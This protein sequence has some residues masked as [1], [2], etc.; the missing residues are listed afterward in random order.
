LLVGLALAADEQATLEISAQ[1][2]AM[3]MAGMGMPDV[4]ELMAG[5][6]PSLLASIPGMADLP[7]PG[8]AMRMLMVQ[9]TSPGI[10]P[11]G[12]TASLAVPPALKL[13][14]RLDLEIARPVQTPLAQGADTG[15]LQLTARFYW[16]SSP[17][18]KPGQPEVLT[19]DA[20]TAE[21]RRAIAQMRADT[22]RQ[23]KPGLPMI[24]EGWTWASW[25]TAEQ[26]GLLAKDAALPGGYALTTNYTGN[27]SLDAPQ[28][29]TFLGPI[30][31]TSPALKE[32]PPL[33]APIVLRWKPV[34]GVLGYSAMIVAMQ[35]QNTLVMWASSEVSLMETELRV[36]F[37]PTEKVA[38]LVES[39][40]LMGPDR[41]E[42]TVPAGIFKD[43][44]TVF[45]MMTGYGPGIEVQGR[46]VA[47]MQ[48]KSALMAMLHGGPPP[49]PGGEGG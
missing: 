1:T 11:E 14:P 38:A 31:L 35:G 44:D 16:G 15:G 48:T 34:P 21:Q 41:T 5:V 45:M 47:R 42:A 43:C 6:D 3:K 17:T 7:M 2:M 36:G 23:G 4:A 46:P 22:E 8:A 49:G 26:R 27:V 18:V 32:E 24:G 30:E 40:V 39:R 9:L 29:M 37:L 20:L 12:A 19:S 28:G 33:D 25:P 10:A 13:G